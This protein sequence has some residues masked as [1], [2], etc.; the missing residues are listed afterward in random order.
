M[1]KHTTGPWDYSDQ[2]TGNIRIVARGAADLFRVAYVPV[3][4]IEDLPDGE[5]TLD[6]RRRSCWR[7]CSDGHPTLRAPKN[8]SIRCSPKH[9]PIA[10]ALG[11]S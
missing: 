2:A 1:S 3:V 6:C 11:K 4:P 9:V 10:K 8:G 5:G 7:R